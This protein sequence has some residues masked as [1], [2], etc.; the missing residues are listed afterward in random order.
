MTASTNKWNPHVRGISV[1]VTCMFHISRSVHLGSQSTHASQIYVCDGYFCTLHMLQ[2]PPPHVTYICMWG[3][4][5]H[6]SYV[7]F[8]MFHM[9]GFVHCRQIPHIRMPASTCKWNPY[10]RSIIPSFH[11][12]HTYAPAWARS[13]N[14]ATNH[15]KP[16]RSGY[17]V[18][19]G[20]G[21]FILL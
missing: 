15:R 17:G 11:L 8:C 9:L 3:V 12:A 10:M 13:K 19:G 5:L 1:C 18:M 6:I 16:V 21:A 7:R 4:F 14:S 20:G 2:S